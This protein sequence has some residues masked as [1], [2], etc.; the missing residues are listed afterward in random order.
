MQV[1]NLNHA[2]PNNPPSSVELNDTNFQ[3][4]IG[5]SGKSYRTLM[6]KSGYDDGSGSI[7]YYNTVAFFKK[8]E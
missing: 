3:R 2:I 5:A 7:V 4:A 1:T 8:R 6:N